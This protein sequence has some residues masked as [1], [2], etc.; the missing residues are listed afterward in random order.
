MGAL[1]FATVAGNYVAAQDQA[2]GPYAK[3][4]SGGLPPVQLYDLAQDVGE[5]DNLHADHPEI[6]R[7]LTEQLDTI[8]TTA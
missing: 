1:R 5:A 8:V 6:I 2:A 3:P 7:Q 4:M